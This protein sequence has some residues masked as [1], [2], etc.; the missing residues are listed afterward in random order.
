L[1]IAVDCWIGV[2]QDTDR[3]VVQVAGRLSIVHV[4][5][6]LTACGSG[7]SLALDLADLLSA[8]TAGIEVIQ[9]LQEQG[10]ALVAVPGYIQLKLEGPRR[11]VPDA[12]S[13]P[14]PRR[15]K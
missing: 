14:G 11:V 4:Q 15:V 13:R 9:Q 3:R 7:G 10:A 6:L 1:E 2:V 12:D 8:D 5:E